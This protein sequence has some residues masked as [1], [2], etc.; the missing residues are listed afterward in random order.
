MSR[1]TFDAFQERC[2]ECVAVAPS[3]RGWSLSFHSEDFE[4]EWYVTARAGTFGAIMLVT[5]ASASASHVPSVIAELGK[6][7]EELRTGSAGASPTRT[8][9][10]RELDVPR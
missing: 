10:L 9:I 3:C 8:A 6:M 5:A 4:R 7:L 1:F 2:R